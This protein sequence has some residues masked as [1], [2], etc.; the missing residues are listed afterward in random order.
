MHCLAQIYDNVYHWGRRDE[1]EWD[2]GEKK[3]E[4]VNFIYIVFQFLKKNL[5]Y[6]QLTLE[7]HLGY[8]C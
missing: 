2:H 3:W 1:D 7:Q 5:K 4:D 6:M 8:G